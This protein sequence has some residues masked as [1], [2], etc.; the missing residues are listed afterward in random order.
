VRS[1]TGEQG[2]DDGYDETQRRLDEFLDTLSFP[3]DEILSMLSFLVDEGFIEHLEDDTYQ[4][5][6]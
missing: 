4:K 1:H 6:V 5:R 3:K 2:R